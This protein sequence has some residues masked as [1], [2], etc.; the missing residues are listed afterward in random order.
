MPAA[1]IQADDECCSVVAGVVLE[2]TI[3]AGLDARAVAGA[4]VE[5]FSL[6]QDDGLAKTMNANVF[7]EGSE[8]L[9][10]DRREQLGER[11]RLQ[12]GWA[13]GIAGPF[14]ANRT[15]LHDRRIASAAVRFRGHAAVS[16]D[17]SAA[18]FAAAARLR[19]CSH[20]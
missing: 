11:V 15:R 4:A 7:Y 18:A 19:R 10:L 6:V 5:D 9:A 8:F 17:R 1:D 2:A 13:I 3:D 20:M 14:S 16:L 12:G